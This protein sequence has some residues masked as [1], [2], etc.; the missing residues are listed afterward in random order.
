M[1]EPPAP[2]PLQSLA[3]AAIDYRRAEVDKLRASEIKIGVLHSLVILLM[4][5][6][7]VVFLAGGILVCASAL[8]M[9]GQGMPAFVLKRDESSFQATGWA[10]GL[11]LGGLLLMLSKFQNWLAARLRARELRKLREVYL[12]HAGADRAES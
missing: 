9:W 2:S 6:W 4:N 7:S 8:V 11:A 1:S 5:L 3:D 12:G 10:L